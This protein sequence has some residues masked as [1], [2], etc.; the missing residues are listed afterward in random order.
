MDLSLGTRH[1]A[2]GAR[3]HDSWVG[4]SVRPRVRASVRLC[5]L[6]T[7]SALTPAPLLAQFDSGIPVG[8]KAPVIKVNDLDGNPVD[9]GAYLGKKPV[10]LEFWASW[11]SNCRGL[12]PELDRVKVKYGDKLVMIGINV[13]VNDS[14]ERARRYM[15]AHKPPFLPL[16]DNTGVSSRAFDVPITSFIVLVDGQGKVAYTGSGKDQDLVA[17][18]GRV[19]Q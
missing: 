3:P 15:E 19:V 18:V 2:L 4:A 8:T 1:P 17:A 9:L 14:R 7:A 12:L 13:T 10:L 5:V 11:C 6:L 16:Y